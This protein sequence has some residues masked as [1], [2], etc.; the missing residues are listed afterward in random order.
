MEVGEVAALI[1]KVLG[2]CGV[3]RPA[4]IGGKADVYLGDSASYRLLL[5]KHK[6]DA[7]PFMEQIGETIDFLRRESN[8]GARQESYA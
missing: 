5:E 4:R 2:G 8:L 7:V 6:I 1:A 3:K